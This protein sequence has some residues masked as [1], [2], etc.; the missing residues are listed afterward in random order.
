MS[1]LQ[2]TVKQ[3]ILDGRSDQ[4]IDTYIS[5]FRAGKTEESSD[6]LGLEILTPLHKIEL[7]NQ[8]L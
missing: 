4:E 8:I 2:A 3:M 1:D 6:E 5:D 7:L